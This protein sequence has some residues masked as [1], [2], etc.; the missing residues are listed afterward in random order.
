MG[1]DKDDGELSDIAPELAAVLDRRA[2]RT[3]T[4]LAAALFCD[5]SSS[6]A[7]ILNISSIGALVESGLVPNVGALV[8]LVRGPL[9]AHALVVWSG[10]GQCGLKFSGCVDVQQWCAGPTNAQQQKVDQVVRLVKAGAMPSS[11]ALDQSVG[12]DEA[13][14]LPGDLKRISCLLESLGNLLASD[15]DVV[16]RHGPALQNLDIAMQLIAAL[17]GQGTKLPGLRA[18]ADEALQRADSVARGIARS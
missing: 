7:R 9:I 2:A 6:P 5:G 8:Q 12:S 18:S 1:G 17:N 14:D 4:F 11:D 15:P 10:E 3:S 16:L 13:G